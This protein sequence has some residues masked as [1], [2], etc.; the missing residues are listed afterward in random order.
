MEEK[1]QGGRWTLALGW[2]PGPQPPL[3][4]SGPRPP[5]HSVLPPCS[6]SGSPLPPPRQGLYSSLSPFASCLCLT[7]PPLLLLFPVPSLLLLPGTLSQDCCLFPSTP[8]PVGSFWLTVLPSASSLFLFQA[9]S[10]SLLLSLWICPSCCHDLLFSQG[11]YF[12]MTNSFLQP[13][14]PCLLTSCC[15]LAASPYPTPLSFPGAPSLPRYYQLWLVH[16]NL[17]D[18]E[19]TTQLFED[20][21]SFPHPKFSLSLPKNHTRLPEEDYSHDLVLLRLAEPAQITDAVRVPDLPPQE[22]Q[23]GSTCYASGW[24]Q[25]LQPGAQTFGSQEEG[26]GNWAPGSGEPPSEELLR[27]HLGSGHSSFFLLLLATYIGNFQ[28]ADL[29]LL[30]KDVCAKACSQK[31]TDQM[32]CAEPLE[33]ISDSCLGNSGSPLICDG[34]LQGITSWGHDTIVGSPQY[35]PACLQQN[36]N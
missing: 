36:K 13:L 2:E 27:S 16:H 32:L 19:D 22:P 23:V 17:F 11:L 6:F 31:M 21:T 20:V 25:T 9:L 7:G 3:Q 28:C 30:P 24:G 10:F 26:A 15:S 35:G 33:T 18:H 29:K 1:V 12:S 14:S 5:P 8:A 34:M 4:L